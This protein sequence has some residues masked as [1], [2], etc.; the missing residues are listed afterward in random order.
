VLNKI[1]NLY[2]KHLVLLV[3]TLSHS[4]VATYVSEAVGGGRCINFCGRT[5][6]LREL[7]ELFCIAD[8]LITND[9]GN[10]HF[11]AM[12]GL[13]NVALYGPETPFMYGPLGKSVCLFEFFHSSPSITTY[14]HKNPPCDCNDCLRSI[15]PDRVVRLAQLIMEDKATYGTVNNEIPYLL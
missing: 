7:L 1:L 10:P 14:N 15:H 4:P 8:L 6:S 3:G 13:K 11:A 2:P 5:A 12:T 9:S